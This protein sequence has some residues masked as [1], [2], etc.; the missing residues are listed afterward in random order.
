MNILILKSLLA[1]ILSCAIA[2]QV[3]A[4]TPTNT[5]QQLAAKQAFESAL[6]N[7]QIRRKALPNN[8]GLSYVQEE[9][10]RVGNGKR[11]Q[12]QPETK[13]QGS[14]I[15]LEQYGKPLES[16]MQF[17][18]PFLIEPDAFSAEQAQL[19]KET[20]STWVFAIPNL[21]KVGLEGEEPAK[22][23]ET[24]EKLDN[25]LEEMLQTEL[26]IDKSRLQFASLHIYSKAPFKPSFLAKVKKFE[27]R[28][29]IAEAWVGGPLIS[30]QTTRSM[31]GSFGF[32][33]KIEEFQ[34]VNI[35]EVKQV[36]L[37]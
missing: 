32:L 7:M 12:F 15:L 30:A 37:N 13:Q 4:N 23:Q 16:N 18:T 21:V 17:E 8:V 29:E 1:T 5:Q 2:C 9:Q 28:I 34:T 36:Q 20:E 35:S 26:V 31:Q 19:I 22:R 10:D 25:Q 14:W 3:N 27:V 33:V 24:E 11:S 6:T